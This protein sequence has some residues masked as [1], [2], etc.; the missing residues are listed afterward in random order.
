MKSENNKETHRKNDMEKV[1]E[2]VNINVDLNDSNSFTSYSYDDGLIIPILF[3]DNHIISAVKPEG[4]LSQADGTDKPDMLTILKKY[5][6]E[7]Y[8]KPG[9]VFLGLVHRLDCPVSGVMIFARTSKG[10]SR[11]SEQI[12][13]RETVKR[14]YVV[15]EGIPSVNKKRL[16]SKISK[17]RYNK[18]SISED[19]KESSLEYSLITSDKTGQYSLLDINLIT[20]RTHQ[21]RLQLKEDGMPIA[22]DRKYNIGVESASQSSDCFNDLKQSDKNQKYDIAL[23]AHSFKFKHPTKDF[24]VEISAVPNLVGYWKYFEELFN[25]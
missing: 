3:E 18:S 1:S 23:F 20:G 24:F 4:V 7:K 5:I 14:Y 25:K 8:Q 9:D 13:N 10:A 19:G 12:R 22:G 11:I 17:G 16:E 21:I 6:K 15:V 2:T